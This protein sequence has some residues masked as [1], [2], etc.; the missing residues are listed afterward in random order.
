MAIGHAAVIVR[1]ITLL[2]ARVIRRDVLRP[3]GP[4]SDLVYPGDASETTRHFGAFDR[5][6][7][8]GAASFL[9]ESCPG[10]DGTGAWRLRGMAITRAARGRGVGSRLL[11]YGVARVVR[12]GASSHMVPRSLFRPLLL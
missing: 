8:V 7:L 9:L 3:Q 12:E 1:S 6:T 11:L 4:E 5:D 2:Q 10:E